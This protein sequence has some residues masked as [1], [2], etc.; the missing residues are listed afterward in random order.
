LSIVP[1]DDRTIRF[2]FCL[3][4]PPELGLGR[5]RVPAPDGR[6]PW[7][8]LVDQI[9]AML[10]DV[11]CI[12]EFSGGCDSSLVLSAATAACRRTGHPDPVPLTYRFAGSIDD[13][14]VRCQAV[15]IE[16]LALKDRWH[17]DVDDADLVG[18]AGSDLL[19]DVG[20]TW[21][22]TLG[23]VRRRWQG[24]PQCLLLSGEGGD[25]ALGPRRTSAFVLLA[26]A[27]RFRQ[28]VRP[29]VVESVRNA[30][31]GALRRR[32][33]ASDLAE[34]GQGAWLEEPERRAAT[35]QLA[36]L[37]AAERLSP[38]RFPEHYLGRP[39]VAVAHHNLRALATRQGVELRMPLAEPAFLACV[40]EHIPWRRH[41]Q[42]RHL[43]NWFFAD[44]LPREVL[45]R[46]TKAIF[47]ASYFGAATRDFA[48]RW[49]GENCPAGVD[50]AVLRRQWLAD[51][52]HIGTA[53]LL[54]QVWMACR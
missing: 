27:I 3:S 29:W 17:V 47:N 38:R 51:T 25:E 21:P 45:D 23:V 10:T 32:L 15:V 40:A 39:W 16:W 9:A 6:P 31:P 19:D 13:D 50:P 28:P 5:P 54:Q 44:H 14:D 18:P 2:G 24:L 53:M 48:T 36:S 34:S 52:P 43:L 42:R 22:A 49:S 4:A 1:A 46:R 20:V 7:Q 41:T 35:Q 8:T 12:V 26:R 33:I 11:P 30:A 37:L